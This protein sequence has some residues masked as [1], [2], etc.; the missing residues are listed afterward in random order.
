MAPNELLRPGVLQGRSVRA[1]AGSRVA[2]LCGALDADLRA[3]GTADV[4]V[5]DAAALFGDGGAEALRVGLDGAWDEIHS[6]FSADNAGKVILLGPRLSAGLHA[7]ALRTG[8]ENLSRTL[9]VEWSRLGIRT[10]TLLPGEQTTDAELA[11]L[12]AYVASEA[13]D[14]FSGSTMTLA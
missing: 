13:G 1:R 3:E 7:E 14:Y 2:E 8:L 9:S 10:V 11:E 6:W 5:V 4:L 12:V